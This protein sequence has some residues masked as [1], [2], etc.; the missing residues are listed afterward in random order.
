MSDDQQL[1]RVDKLREAANDTA[2][3]VRTVYLTFLLAGIYVATL[4]GSTTDEQLL[5]GSLVTLPIVNLAVPIR[6][7]YLV[8]PWLFVLLHFNL[9]MQLYFLSRKLHAFQ[10]SL[11]ALPGDMLRREQRA[12]LFPLPFA[13]MLAGE[14]DPRLTWILTKLMVWITVL[15]LPIGVLVWMQV[16]F[17]PYHDPFVTWMHRGAIGVDLMFIWML[18]P[19]MMHRDGTWP[20]WWKK[21]LKSAWGLAG[22]SVFGF[23]GTLVVLGFCLLIAA[24]PGEEL[25]GWVRWTE[26]K[27]GWLHRNLVLRDKLL[28]PGEAPPEI[29]RAYDATDAEGEGAR[30]ATFPGLDL[31]GR[32]LRNA[33]F[34]RSRLLN[35]DL[36]GADL[37]SANLKEADLRGARLEALGLPAGGS[38]FTDL[39]RANLRLARLE[40][41]DLSEAKLQGAD[42]QGARLQG[43][44]LRGAELQGADLAFAKLQGANL[45]EAELQG[46]DLFGAQLQGAVL[47]DPEPVPLWGADLLHAHLQGANL[48]FAE[49]QGANLAFAELQG[50]DLSGAELQG[51]DLTQ[52][53]LQGADLRGAE[54]QGADLGYASL[55]GSDLRQTEFQL[56]NL[57]GVNFDALEDKEWDELVALIRETV[58]EGDEQKEALDRLKEAREWGTQFDELVLAHA[59]GAIYGKE[60]R[61]ADWPEPPDEKAYG[62][63]LTVYLA[64]LS[65][66]GEFVARNIARRVITWD[67]MPFWGEMPLRN[68]YYPLLAQKLVSEGCAGGQQLPEEVRTKLQEIAKPDAAPVE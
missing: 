25:D 34:F 3:N 68:F 26:V 47:Y 2:R 58:P 16:Q 6:G 62:S 40:G 60:G 15:V 31:A 67:E 7:F 61:F 30:L 28:V 53:K 44:N 13:H 5:R 65:C 8:V 59:D 39:R 33:D 56:S 4:I 18:W 43:A 52:A 24:V 29:V 22:A 1:Q 57:R 36:R 10:S 49:L 66:G 54:L 32:D 23:T 64:E 41:V 11:P 45:E 46:A 50:A 20:G 55:G 51:A 21:L 17:L 42:L 12:M 19:K 38:K 48:A 14:R 37:R 63:N 27:D 35:A 9:L